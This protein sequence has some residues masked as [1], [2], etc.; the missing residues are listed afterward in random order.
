MTIKSIFHNLKEITMRKIQVTA[1]MS[2]GNAPD[3]VRLEVRQGPHT[4]RSEEVD[5][6]PAD[7]A[8]AQPG[9]VSTA[10]AKTTFELDDGDYVAAATA[11]V[12]HGT[13]TTAIFA[14]PVVVR[15]SAG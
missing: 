12:P 10:V 13:A 6:V 14:V 9:A 3:K 15:V 11:L 7:T 1:E 5:V 4:L 8:A 2:A